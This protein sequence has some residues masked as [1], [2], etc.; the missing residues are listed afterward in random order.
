M[1]QKLQDFE[2]STVETVAKGINHLKIVFVNAYFIDTKDSWVLVDTGLP[3]TAWRIK[4]YAETLYG[5]NAKPAAIVLT[6]GH[7]DHAGSALDLAKEWNVPV[8]AHRLEMPYL[9]GKSDYPPQDPTVGGALAQMSRMFPRSGFDLGEHVKEISAD[10]KIKELPEWEI[11]HTPGHTAGH[12]S[13]FRSSDKTLLAGDALATMNQD[14]WISNITE[15]KE[16][17]GPPAPFT[18]DW[19]AAR[20]SVEKLAELAPNVVAAGHGQPITENTAARLKTFAGNFQKPA[21]GRYVNQPAIADETGVVSVPPSVADPVRNILIGAG[22]IGGGLLL[23]RFF[24][25]RKNNS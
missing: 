12:I 20:R 18:T 4:S 15:E 25:R 8:Y 16:F 17:N 11:V 24:K 9:N 3:L 14:S 19:E 6:H 21:H 23:A 5:E 1:S 7:F 2:S 10:N 22:A 13:L